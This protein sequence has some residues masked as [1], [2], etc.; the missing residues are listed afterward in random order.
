MIESADRLDKSIAVVVGA[1]ED[2][3][4]GCP[5]VMISINRIAGA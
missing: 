3:A 2:G 1:V 4:K 5:A